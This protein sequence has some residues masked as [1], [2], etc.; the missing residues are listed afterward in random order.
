MNTFRK[1]LLLL[2]MTSFFFSSCTHKPKGEMANMS[3]QNRGLAN[4]GT[5][6]VF[7]LVSD[8]AYYW[9]TLRTRFPCTKGNY[10][11]E[12]LTFKITENERDAEDSNTKPNGVLQLG[13]HT[14]SPVTGFFGR[15]GFG[16]LI[17]VQ[18]VQVDGQTLYNV[19]LSLCMIYGRVSGR[20]SHHAASASAYGV[21]GTEGS[22]DYEYVGPN[23]G[24]NNF[25]ISNI[26]L[27]SSKGN[28][29]R[30]SVTAG[31]LQFFSRTYN[32]PHM[33]NFSSV[34]IQF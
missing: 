19:A 33:R 6:N 10:R 31:R 16:D 5:Q 24:L 26:I 22:Y 25:S 32:G 8:D 7:P 21:L 1:S 20:S 2:V 4:S 11:M 18:G 30:G 34:N 12:D 13:T 3:R 29:F 17:Y 27:N 28:P 23:V 15:S 14:G 9:G